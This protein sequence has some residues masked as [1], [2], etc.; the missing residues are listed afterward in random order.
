MLNKM[1]R[2]FLLFFAA[3]VLAFAQGQAVNQVSGPPPSSWVSQLS[4]NGSNQITYVCSAPA[5]VSQTVFYVSSSTLTNVVVSSNTGTIT[6]ANPGTAY[7]WVGQ[8]ITL[9]GSATTALNA[10]YKVLTVSGATATITTSGVSNGTYADSTLTL[11]TTGPM[12]NAA[13]WSIQALTYASGNLSGTYWAGPPSTVPA[14]G[15]KC[16]SQ[17][18]Y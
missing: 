14:Q 3:S 16:S 15:L 2:K 12:L 1:L 4:Y 9:A 5:L 13:V 11:T 6:F 18:S 7:L 10:T 8:Q 17:G